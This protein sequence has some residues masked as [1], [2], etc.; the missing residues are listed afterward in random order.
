MSQITYGL[1]GVCVVLI[2]FVSI[3]DTLS[4]KRKILL[5]CIAL[6][7]MLLIVTD[8]LSDVY[9]GA[10]TIQG[11]YA[12]RIN[13]FLAYGL[14]LAVIFSFS[15][16]LKDLLKGGN[17]KEVPRSVKVVDYILI[18]ATITLV[19]SQFTG[20]YYYYDEANR[21]HRGI[22]YPGSYLF[23]FA[24]LITL[25]HAI[26]KYREHLRKRL[27]VPLLLFTIMPVVM[28]V[29][30]YFIDRYT[31]TSGSIVAMAVLLYSFSILDAN[32][33]MRSAKEKEIETQ[34]T[35]LAQTAAALAEAIDAKDAYTNG[36]SR[37]VAE[38]SAEIAE[39][40]GKSK[41]ECEEI[42]LI[43]LLH[44]VGKIGVPNSIINKT[45]R[46][47]DEEYAII[48]THPVRGKEILEKISIAPNLSIGA[49]YHHE[50]FDGRGYPEGLKG[51]QIPEI[52][53]IIAVA[54]SYDAMT[55]RRSY[56]DGL[57]IEKVK[58]E[59]ISGMGTQFDTRFANIMIELIDEPIGN[60]VQFREKQDKR[61]I[62][63]FVKAIEEE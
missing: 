17:L 26:T 63:S 2:I 18:A 32:D 22:F 55:S 59:L 60:T 58:H 15:Q 33:A 56:R 45:G 5:A 28:S 21:Y 57:P 14:N 7:A 27:I 49:H 12:V 43:A 9:D 23:A 6:S 24:A 48:K 54:D 36:H 4:K 25:V 30:H 16:Y 42:Y 40:Y 3:T 53:R 41:E 46:L 20:L 19:V 8:H 1:I 13:K 35:M 51:E 44:D 11:G 38:Y 29:I 62:E 61:F 31:L 39:R 50:R 34:K 10:R 37:R 47:T 52:A